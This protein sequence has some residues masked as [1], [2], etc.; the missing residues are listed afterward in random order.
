MGVASV[1]IVDDTLCSARLPAAIIPLI[2]RRR[3]A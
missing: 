3:S 2:E 1:S